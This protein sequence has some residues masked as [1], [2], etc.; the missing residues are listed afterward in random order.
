[1]TEAVDALRL[2]RRSYLSS[3]ALGALAVLLIK[4]HVALAAEG[5]A[6]PPPS[7]DP[8]ASGPQTIVVAGGCFWGVQGV[9]QHVRGVTNAVSGYAGGAKADAQYEIVSS[10]R[11]GH[12]ESV[13]ISFDPTIISLGHLL[14]IFFSVALDPT[15]VNRQGPDVGSQYRSVIFASDEAQAAT[16]RAYIA[17]LDAAKVFAAPIATQVATGKTFYPA[18]GYHQNF[19]TEHPTYPYIVYNDLPKLANLKKLFPAD[20]RPD[21]VLVAQAG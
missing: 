16:A 19:L 17:Q 15:E 10:G 9:F 20:Y 4:P 18:E 2:S 7:V 12:A 6:A 11:T 1:M 14:Q 3:C 8:S 21:P 13:Q 5:V